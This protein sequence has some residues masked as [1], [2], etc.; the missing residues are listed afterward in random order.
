MPEAEIQKN[1]P[2]LVQS[3]VYQAPL[4]R[5]KQ[6]KGQ[7]TAFYHDFED[8]QYAIKKSKDY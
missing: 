1:L 5:G 8:K 7:Y 6:E 3:L 2:F 4:G